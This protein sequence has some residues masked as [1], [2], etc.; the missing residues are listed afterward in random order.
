MPP[1][2]IAIF[3]RR[4]TLNHRGRRR[5]RLIPIVL[6]LIAFVGAVV[7]AVV[8]YLPPRWGP[9][10]ASASLI[11]TSMPS[12]VAVKVDGQRAGRT[13]VQL[14]VS[15]GDHRLT[16]RGSSVVATTADVHA[17]ADQ[18][19]NVQVALWLRSPAADQ[20]RPPFPGAAIATAGF[21]ADGRVALVVAM[22]PGDDRQLWVRSGDGHLQAL[23]PTVAYGAVAPSPDGR[24][25]AYLAPSTTPASDTPTPSLTTLRIAASDVEQ[26]RELYAV[27]RDS[28]DELTDLAWSPDGGHL[29]LVVRHKASEGASRTEVR[30]LDVRQGSARTLVDLPSTIVAGSFAWDPRGDRVAFLT[31]SGPLVSLCVLGTTPP[32][33]RY[34]ADLSQGDAKPL[35]FPP[36]AWS[37]DGSHLVYAAPVPSRPTTLG[38]WLFGTRSALA[39]FATRAD[40]GASRRLGAAQANA[41]V[42]RADGSVLTLARPSGNGPITLQ[43]VDPSNGAAESLGTFPFPSAPTYAVRWDPAQGQALVAQREDDGVTAYWL[44]KFT[45]A[46]Q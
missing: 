6:P 30:W 19:R 22:P 5:G 15:P 2:P 39:L 1:N 13:P 36:L 11:V 16:F 8:L 18:T 21:L 44:L 29:L 12:N 45:E 25:V 20:I 46:A 28:G 17:A 23:G 14:A 38:G 3:T 40:G 42:W 37:P 9:A 34:L 33:F 27:A 43:S 7:V 35:P 4:A 32:S 24:Q 10:A 41:P 31:Q 26:E